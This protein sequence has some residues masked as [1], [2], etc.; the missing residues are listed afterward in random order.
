[1]KL[2]ALNQYM[3]LEEAQEILDPRMGRL[4]GELKNSVNF[5][6]PEMR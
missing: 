1:M 3:S 4:T 6:N 2:N 5:W